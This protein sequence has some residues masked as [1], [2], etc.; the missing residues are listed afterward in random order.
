MTD[1]STLVELKNTDFQPHIN[2]EFTSITKN[3]NTKAFELL[4]VTNLG[5]TSDNDSRQAFSLV[6]RGENSPQPQQS[7]YEMDHKHLG[8]LKLFMVP[9]GPD[10]QGMRYEAVFT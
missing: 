7:I 10:Q 9:I 3:G 6:F 1:K 8:Q 2:S 4:E 5:C